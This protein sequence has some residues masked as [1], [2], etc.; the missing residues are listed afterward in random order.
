MWRTRRLQIRWCS[1]TIHGSIQNWDF[2]HC[3]ILNLPKTSQSTGKRKSTIQTRRM[4][5]L[6]RTARGEPSGEYL[7]EEH[8]LTYLKRFNTFLR[9]LLVN[10]PQITMSRMRNGLWVAARPDRSDSHGSEC[11]RR[12]LSQGPTEADNPRTSL[13]EYYT[14]LQRLLVNMPQMA[15]SRMWNGLTRPD[16]SDSYSSKCDRSALL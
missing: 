9:R 3:Q 13:E 6:R 12:A 16:R 7:Q 11:D 8:L 4:V 2:C 5:Y 1:M 10:K 15:M 14:P